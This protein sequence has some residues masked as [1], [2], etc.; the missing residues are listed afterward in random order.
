MKTGFRKG[1]QVYVKSLD[2]RVLKPD[3]IRVK[4]LACGV[5]GTDIHADAVTLA[6]ERIMTGHEITGEVIE[7]GASVAGLALGQRIVLDSATPC[8]RCDACRNARQELC[9]DIQSFFFL[10]SFGFSD[11]MVA[12]A[13]CAI[14]CADLAPEIACLQEPLGVA[15][16]L[17]RLSD[18]TPE[19]NVLVLGQG[20]IGLMATALVHNMGARRVFTTE[21]KSRQKRVE[22]S[23][24]F[25]ADKCL[26]PA[27]TN[28]ESFD[29]GCKIDRI[30]VTA[31]PKVLP[32]AFNIACKGGIISFIGIGIGEGA[33]IS[34]DAN[35][36][37]FK[38]LQ[39]RASFA[40]PAQFGPQ[41]LRYLREG[42]IDGKAIVTH[43]FGLDRIAEAIKVV[44]TDSAAVKVV[45]VP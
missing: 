7:L 34:F 25:G 31:P 18:I 14:P 6:E 33:K 20:P 38:K 35:D 26:D 10:D 23:L 3:Q 4:V 32:S 24:K 1:G 11:E 22:L 30:L 36:F 16:D 44:Q 15:I 42:V 19:S 12:P 39:L 21:L 17:V 45:V 40:S 9:S 43:T 2:R 5:C 27:E 29:F 41:A 13:I 8:G 28:L 37:H